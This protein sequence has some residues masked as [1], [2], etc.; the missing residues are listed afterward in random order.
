VTAG[1][2]HVDLLNFEYRPTR[3]VSLVPSMTDSLFELGLGEHL[4]GVTDYC[5][6][7]PADEARLTRVGGTRAP[8]AD[9]IVELSPDLVLANQEETSRPSVEK[10]E[11]AGLK[12]WTTFPRTAVEAVQVL[13][14]VLG[15]F[16]AQ[17]AA[18]RVATLELTLDWARRASEGMQLVSYFCPI[19]Q[20]ESQAY[21]RWWMS[22]NDSTYSGD[23][24]RVCGGRNVFAGR[25]RRYPLAADLGFAEPEP[26]GEHDTRYPRFMAQEV[27]NTQPE[28]ILLP[29]EPYSFGEHE[30][31]EIKET[32]AETPAGR[33]GRIKRVDGRLVT[34][35][36]TR[37]ASALSELP[38]LFQ[39]SRELDAGSA[40]SPIP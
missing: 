27:I 38:A 23:L 33:N 4:V 21:G 5:Q 17:E 15:V 26:P 30:F 34:W 18:G 11:R 22:F 37:M 1:N 29:D 28:V 12:V 6:P 13:W 20:A 8:D 24:L 14:A 32:F 25:S 40:P 16:R 10:L 2:G 3:V 19:W 7:P 36:G 9:A 35:H 39:E 31:D